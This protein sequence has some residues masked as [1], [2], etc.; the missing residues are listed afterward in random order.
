MTGIE[1][2]IEAAGSETALGEVLGVSQ[3]AVNKWKVQGY[4]PQGR[5]EQLSRMYEIPRDDL[6]D[7][8]I[9]ALFKDWELS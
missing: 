7:P 2:A 5:V 1:K 3:Q 4:V 6:L 8:Q 9:V